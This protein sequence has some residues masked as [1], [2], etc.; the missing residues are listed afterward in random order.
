MKF[1][2]FWKAKFYLDDMFFE[3]T[4]TV[5]K[6]LYFIKSLFGKSKFMNKNV[7]LKGLHTGKRVFIIGNGPSVKQQN[8]KVLKDEIVF[9]VNRGYMHEDYEYIKPNYHVFV[10]PKLASGE[11]DISMLDEVLKKNP[12]VIFLLNSKWY[13]LDKFKPYLN[14]QKY[15]IYW[16]NTSLF[17]TPFYKN[18]IIDLKYATYGGAV[19]GQAIVSAVYMGAKNIYLIGV[20][21]TGLCHELLKEN[22]HFYGVNEENDKKNM[23]DIYKDFYHSYLYLKYLYNF[24]QYS[25]DKNFK[26]INCSVGGILNMFDRQRYEDLL[27]LD[28]PN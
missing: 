19:L 14:D 13:K 7:E 23:V 3:L 2:N 28:Q 26:V 11:W 16:L 24:S 9:S 20:E 25:K 18:R 17:F 6:I 15:K 12:G 5:L 27:L 1:F 10:D 8:I 21:S 22:S 4:N